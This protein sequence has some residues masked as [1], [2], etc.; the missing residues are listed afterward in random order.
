VGFNN[1]KQ[2]QKQK[3]NTIATTRVH[4][5]IG[6][7]E[8]VLQDAYEQGE[9]WLAHDAKQPTT[10]PVHLV[11][12]KKKK[13]TQA[14]HLSMSRFR[15]SI[16]CRVRVQN[17]KVNCYLQPHIEIEVTFYI[18]PRERSSTMSPP[19]ENCG[20][21]AYLRNPDEAFKSEKKLLSITMPSLCP[22]SIPY[23]PR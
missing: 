16:T 19:R 21:F 6:P 7:T 10:G 1:Q 8:N 13:N 9:G 2:K 17:Y 14:Q 11:I 23:M 12:K 15:A 20:M 22:T 3:R 4:G 18:E 5:T